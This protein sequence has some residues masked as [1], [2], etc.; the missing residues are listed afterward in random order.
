MNMAIIGGSGHYPLALEALS[1]RPDLTLC[2]I[3]PSDADE[4]ISG[5]IAACRARGLTP[6]LHENAH[7]L[8]ESHPE[9]DLAAVNPWFSRAA[10]VS[11]ACLERGIHVFSEK[12]LATTLPKLDALEKAWRV[13]GCA[14]GGMFNLRYCG[15]FRTVER[16]V[17]EGKI[18]VVRQIQARK[19]YK[20]GNRPE[21]YRHRETFGGII[22][23]V[24]I[25]AIDWATQLGG[26]CT[27]AFALTNADYNRGHGD[28]EM[29]S[30]VLMAL[31]NGA[32]ATV[33]ADFLR[34]DGA[35]RHDDDRLRVTG[36][37]GTLYAFDGQ[38]HIEDA[39]GTRTLPLEPDESCLLNLID[40]IGTPAAES[41]AQAD[42]AVTRT[43]LEANAACN[44]PI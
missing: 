39:T 26:A 42:L 4:D 1:L 29:T 25:H 23:W 35:A 19:S 28:L 9:L 22:P 24:G 6:Q 34:P 32:I 20:L 5:L 44:A 41:R 36:T 17:A 40:A 43:A 18:G 7:A 16:A 11:I 12:P 37:T 14:L 13:S 8:L 27:R 21:F 15:W 38:V 10:D 3:A 30:A 31:Q 2:A 33:T